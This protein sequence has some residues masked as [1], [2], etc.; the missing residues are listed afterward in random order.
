[1]QKG[2]PSEGRKISEI[3]L[4]TQNVKLLGVDARYDFSN[5]LG[6]YAGYK[7]NITTGDGVMDELYWSYNTNPD[8]ISHWSHYENTDVDNVSILDLGIKY[9]FNASN[10]DME[11]ISSINTWIS[12]GYRQENLELKANDGYGVYLGFSTSFSGLVAT[13]KQEYK[14]PYL[15]IGTDFKN[16]SYILNLGFK[17]S[18]FMS[19]EYSNRY[20]QRTPLLTQTTNFDETDMINFNIGLGYIINKNQT[21][22]L[23]YE[24]TKYDYILGTSEDLTVE[25]TA[26]DSKNSIINVAYSYSF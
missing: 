9:G 8:F 12:L 13:Y 5:G 16:E 24:Y 3:T 11:A 23:S 25:P 21:I 6:F 4:K 18:P 22:S 1:M 17:Y 15:G 26:L 2:Y 19:S 7:K 10:L 20:H 14:G